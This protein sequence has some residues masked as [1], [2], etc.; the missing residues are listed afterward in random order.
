MLV[1]LAE[2]TRPIELSNTRDEQIGVFGGKGGM[3]FFPSS[4]LHH[5]HSR[6]KVPAYPIDP[7]NHW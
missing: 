4:I 5:P 3:N 1:G 2:A 6:T 7:S